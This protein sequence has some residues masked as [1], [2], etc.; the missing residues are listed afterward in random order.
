M[1]TTPPGGAPIARVEHAYSHFRITMHAFRCRLVSGTPDP[2]TG[3]PWAWAPVASLGD[4]AFP[5]ANRRVLEA[6]EAETREPRLL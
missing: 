6:L 4:Y 2:S 3:E 1:P 5:R